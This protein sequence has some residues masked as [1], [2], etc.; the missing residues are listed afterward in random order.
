MTNKTCPCCGYPSK[1]TTT[2]HCSACYTWFRRN[3]GRANADRIEFLES[4]FGS[5]PEQHINNPPNPA[6]T[7]EESVR[8]F[9]ERWWLGSLTKEALES[10]AEVKGG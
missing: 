9:G 10:Y 4:K 3:P 1:Y 5:H 6:M 2:G 8:T 7:P